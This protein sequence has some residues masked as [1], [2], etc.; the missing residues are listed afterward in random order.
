MNPVI[1][2]RIEAPELWMEYSKLAK[3]SEISAQYELSKDF[4][5]LHVRY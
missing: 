2:A 1:W 5:D 3:T 4:N